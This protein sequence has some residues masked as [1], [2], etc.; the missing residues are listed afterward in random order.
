MT[1]LIGIG[2]A[3]ALRGGSSGLALDG[4]G[5]RA[6]GRSARLAAAPAPSS[7]RRRRLSRGAPARRG[8]TSSSSTSGAVARLPRRG[9]RLLGVPPLPRRPPARPVRGRRGRRRDLLRRQHGPARDGGGLEGHERWWSAWRERFAWL[10]AHYL[11]YGFIGAMIAFLYKNVG[12]SGLLVFALPLYAQHA[13]RPHPS[14]P[15]STRKPRAAAATINTQNQSLEQANKLAEGALHRG[16]GEPLGNRRRARRLHGRPF[17]PRAAARPCDRAGARP[18][19]GGARPPRPRCALPRHR[20]ARHPG[21]D[22]PEAE[23]PHRRRVG[24]DA[25]PRRGS[26]ARHRPPGFARTRSRRFAITTSA[27]T[28]PAIRTA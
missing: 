17:A 5:R 18:L 15:S 28:A 2:Q 10:T 13:G 3:L 26:G 12:I 7:R 23:R 21:L 22:P 8:S 9:R 24:D 4:R 25:Q 6:C 11:F 19:A 16:D 20:Q 14:T 27:T 1:V